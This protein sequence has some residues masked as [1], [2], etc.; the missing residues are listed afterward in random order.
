MGMSA[1]KI[2]FQF[3]NSKGITSNSKETTSNSKGITSNSRGSTVG[4]GDI[5]RAVK[6]RV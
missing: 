6:R 4:K 1:D 2:R 5:L 3:L